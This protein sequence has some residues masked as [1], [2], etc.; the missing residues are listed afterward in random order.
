MI[1]NRQIYHKT[2]CFKE[3]FLKRK[4]IYSKEKINQSKQSVS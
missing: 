1:H 4:H 3:I 2:Y